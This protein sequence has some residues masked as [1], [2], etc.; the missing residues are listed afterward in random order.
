M[1]IIDPKN[2]YIISILS[3]ENCSLAKNGY[4]IKDLRI[5]EDIPLSDILI[6]DN[7]SHSF[8]Y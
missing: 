4:Y 6:V 5:I 8:G 2:E 1:D 3:R 7:L